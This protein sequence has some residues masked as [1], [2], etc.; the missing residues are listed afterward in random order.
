MM[1]RHRGD[2]DRDRDEDR[3]Y[4]DRN[5]RD[6][7]FNLQQRR[8][9]RFSDAPPLDDHR[10]P[11][12][13]R[14]GFSASRRAFDSPP[15][16]PHLSNSGG[17]HPPPGG[18]P[19]GG[20]WPMGGELGGPPGGF[21]NDFPGPPRPMP[22]PPSL[23]GQKRG[24]RAGSPEHFD[25]KSFVKLFVGSVPRTV[26]EEEIRPLF[27][28]QGKVLEVAL[29]K[30]KRTGQQQGMYIVAVL[31][32]CCL[33]SF[34]FSGVLLCCA[35][36]GSKCKLCIVSVSFFKN[37]GLLIFV[38]TFFISLHCQTRRSKGCRPT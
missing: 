5:N 36:D 38:A 15:N 13:Q 18:G 1:E 3:D 4:R 17:F 14:G 22:P 33:Y 35:A 10:S 2:R 37:S 8:P 27:E 12:N 6:R 11:S 21:G 9:S 29:I 23:S 24:F 16:Q 19:P 7:N 32:N 25:G 31:N 34:L 26:T 30:D 20:F 28:E